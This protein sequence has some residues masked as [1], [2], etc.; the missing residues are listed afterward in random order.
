MCSCHVSS[1]GRSSSES[2]RIFFWD[3]DDHV[4]SVAQDLSSVCALRVCYIGDHGASPHPRRAG[5]RQ[6]VV[7]C[8]QV[9]CRH[10]Q[11]HFEGVAPGKELRWS[12]SLRSADTRG[13][14]GWMPGA[15]EHRPKLH[16]AVSLWRIGINQQACRQAGRLIQ[17]A[18]RPSGLGGGALRAMG[19]CGEEAG[20]RVCVCGVWRGVCVCVCTCY[21]RAMCVLCACHVCALWSL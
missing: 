8:R 17:L 9:E 18:K 14:F 4:M 3:L 10:L 12:T 7:R 1:P 6:R 20:R 5:P 16:F 11:L 15:D 21:V 19:Q 13:R 2:Q